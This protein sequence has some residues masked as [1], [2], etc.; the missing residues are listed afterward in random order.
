MLETGDF[1]ATDVHEWH[2]NTEFKPVNKNITGGANENDVL[3]N[4]HF[5]RLSVVCYLRDKMI[6]C[7]NM[8]ENRIQLLKNN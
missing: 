4:W 5:N 7:K 1:L 8:K 2:A 6:Q 3:N